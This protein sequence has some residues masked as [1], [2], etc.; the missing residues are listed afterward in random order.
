MIPGRCCRAVRAAV[1]AATCVLLAA[2]GHVLMSGSAVPWWAMAA[3]FAT[4]AATAWLFSRR[5]RGVLAV[6]SMVVAAQAALHTGFSLAQAAVHPSVT[7]SPSFARQWAE[8]LLCGSAGSTSISQSE[9]VRIVTEAGLGSRLHQPPPG[10]TDMTVAGGMQHA[11]AGMQTM[12]DPATVMPAG[13]DMAGMSP[14][15]MLAAHLLAAL[16]CGLWLA[17]GERSAFRL[18]R[19]FAG[20]IIAPLCLLSRLSTPPHRPRI[21]ARRDHRARGP[22]QLFLIHALTSRGPPTGIAVI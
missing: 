15:G 18:L 4:A 5:E 10:T 9:A 11:H 13:H 7:N 12:T 19:T 20:W 1:F 21:R 8:S 16:L 17:Y 6:T 14:A 3:A 2:L 22:R